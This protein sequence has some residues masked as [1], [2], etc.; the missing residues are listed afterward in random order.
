MG[1]AAHQKTTTFLLPDPRSYCCYC[2]PTPFSLARHHP[3]PAMVVVV[4]RSR[5]VWRGR[6]EIRVDATTTSTIVWTWPPHC[7]PTSRHPD[8]ATL[9][10]P[11]SLPFGSSSRVAVVIVVELDPPPTPSRTCQCLSMSTDGLVRPLCHKI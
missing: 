8:Q 3:D 11:S 9:P 10:L 2:I 4:S 5:G 7:S 6:W 1:F